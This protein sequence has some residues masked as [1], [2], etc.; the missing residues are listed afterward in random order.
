MSIT[1]ASCKGSAISW[2]CCTGVNC[3]LSSCTSGSQDGLRD[4]CETTQGFSV[5]VPAADTSVGVEYHDGQVQNCNL[6]APSLVCG[7]GTAISG[8]CSGN[9]YCTQSV[10]LT[11]CST[12]TAASTTVASPLTSIPSP[13]A[14]PSGS[15]SSPVASPTG[16]SGS[17]PTG[18]SGNGSED[19]ADNA[20]EDGTDG[21]SRKLSSDDSSGCGCESEGS[22]N[23]EDR[24]LSGSDCGGDDHSKASLKAK[25]PNCFSADATVLILGKGTVA[26]K[27]V[28]VGDFALSAANKYEPVYAFAHKDLTATAEFVQT[29][30]EK[31]NQPLEVTAKHL[32]FVQGNSYPILAEQLKIGDVLYGD[33]NTHLRVQNIRRQ[34][35]QDGVYA[36]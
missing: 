20:T 11:S 19:E 25:A 22:D 10:D 8:S 34:T 16:S 18:C 26:M 31:K 29:F 7:G 32:V 24:K 21:S 3:N 14:S 15:T 28:S 17:S 30:I 36:P 33:A 23:G 4:K 6:A 1:F 12:T 5:T 2:A 27:D 9:S 35:R 13:V